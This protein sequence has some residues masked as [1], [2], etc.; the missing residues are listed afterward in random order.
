VVKSLNEKHK[1][2]LR[3]LSDPFV[4]CDLYHRA[5]HQHSQ[6]LKDHVFPV[7]MTAIGPD[8]PSKDVIQNVSVIIFA[9]PT[10]GLRYASDYRPLDRAILVV[11]DDNWLLTCV[12][13][14]KLLESIRGS[15]DPKNLP[16]LIFVNKGI[17]SETGALTLE[18]ILDTCG[19]EI[20][21]QATFLVCMRCRS[22]M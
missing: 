11:M 21:T 18:I 1:V 8:L 14:R 7:N 20:A 2:R 3:A 4:G 10:Q 16:L 12:L 22:P 15:L 9:I 17:E 13:C 5:F 19:R 6:F